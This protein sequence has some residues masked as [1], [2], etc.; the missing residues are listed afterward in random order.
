[1]GEP[2]SP[3]KTPLE[4]P[5]PVLY[6]V[7]TIVGIVGGSMAVL[8]TVFFWISKARES[9]IVLGLALKQLGAD[10]FR[11]QADLAEVRILVGRTR[12]GH[13]E[14]MGIVKSDRRYREDKNYI[15]RTTIIAGDDLLK[16]ALG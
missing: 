14:F 8:S 15:F 7:G 13:R 16:F 3:P 1:M 9:D 5:V 11:L 12:A 10:I 4:N 2:S 6:R